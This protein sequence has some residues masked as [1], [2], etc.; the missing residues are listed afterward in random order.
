VA[1]ILANPKY[2]GYMVL[3]RTRR[4]HNRARP[5]PPDQWTWSAQPTHEALVDKATWDAA[6]RAG[7]QHGNVRD[8][9][10]PTTR[11]GRRYRLRSRI[12]CKIC[13][14]RMRGATRTGPAY[15]SPYIYYRCPHDKSIPRHAAAHPSHPSVIV[16]EDDL[17]TALAGFF[18]ERVFGPDRAAMLTAQL[19]AS[20][21]EQAA[22]R[23]DK[24]A[25]LRRQL[26]RIDT[27]E[28][29]LIT[30]LEAPA[31][32]GDPAAQALRQRIRA[33]FTDLFTERTR[34]VGELAA[35]EAATTQDN[36]PTLLDT[37]PI[38]G[39]IVTEAPGHLI[40]SLLDAFDVSAVYNNDLHQV[41]INA[42]ITDASPQAITRLLADPRT[43]QNAPAPV[44]A[45][46]DHSCHSA[47]DTGVHALAPLRVNVSAL[48]RAGG[49]PGSFLLQD[50]LDP[51]V[52]PMGDVPQGGK[53][54]PGPG[55]GP[56]GGG[57]WP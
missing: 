51:E 2:T 26:A 47:A 23:Q 21:A 36:D 42:T 15:R 50:A 19:P 35:L 28:N 1:R 57:C 46:E 38:L 6:Q 29:A 8:T 24:A 55:A 17:M 20:A 13:H 37:L 16:R 18:T 7:T 31:T 4:Q 34:I 10:M 5:M 3:G 44:P 56:Q 32:P 25:A 53:R 33:R 49:P 9:E 39:D 52:P 30:E 54:G 45:A 27:A 22:Q 14:R 12:W 11:P 48:C 41:T 43:D 40:E